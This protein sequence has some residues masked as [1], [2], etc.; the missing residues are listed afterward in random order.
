M[1]RKYRD[2][3][4]EKVGKWK[5]IPTTEEERQLFDLAME[6]ERRSLLAQDFADAIANKKRKEGAPRKTAGDVE[7]AAK[8]VEQHDGNIKLARQEFMKIVMGRDQI[9]KKRARE[10]FGKALKHRKT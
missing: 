2:L 4:H 9:E 8:L 3:Y 7:L 1:S 10:R 6:E 5:A